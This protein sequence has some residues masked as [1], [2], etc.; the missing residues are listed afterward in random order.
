MLA[1]M[2][3]CKFKSHPRLV[4]TEAGK[5]HV[6]DIE[7]NFF[8]PSRKRSWSYMWA[9]FLGFFFFFSSASENGSLLS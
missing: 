1:K 3:A 2:N 6:I 5:F 7:L 4:L 9:F 8:V